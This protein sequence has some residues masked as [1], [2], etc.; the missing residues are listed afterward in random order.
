MCFNAAKSWFT[1][2]YSEAGKEGHQDLNF[3]DTPGQWWK[4]KLVGIDDYLNDIFDE[5]EHRVVA[6]TPG[7]FTMFNRAK[8]VNAGVKAYPNQVVIV[9][10][11]GGR[12][13]S[14]VLAVLDEETHSFTFSSVYFDFDV[15][16]KVCQI[17]IPPFTTGPQIIG[18]TASQ[19]ST[20]STGVAS[21]AI[22]GNLDAAYTGG[23]VTHTNGE[24]NPWWKVVLDREEI[25]QRIRVYNRGDSCC[26]S[27]LDNAIIDLFDGNGTLVFTRNIGTAENFKAINLERGYSVKE[28]K[29]RL[30][31]KRVLSLAEVELF[32]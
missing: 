9:N 30:L 5:N 11:W 26:R 3:F 18:G 6:R 27:R 13:R 31:G 24:L 22:D 16:I 17:T 23:S 8:G 29:I 4:G 25:V 21:L 12:E 28:V 14:K 32:A 15:T 20:Y 7:L 2:W 10:Q 1:S 19:S